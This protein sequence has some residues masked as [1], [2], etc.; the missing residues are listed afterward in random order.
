MFKFNIKY[1]N[2]VTEKYFRFQEPP[3]ITSFTNGEI[4]NWSECAFESYI[5]YSM[6]S[7]LI[8]YLLTE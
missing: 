8:D 4:I 2:D 3:P 6:E 7:S 1:I 5:S